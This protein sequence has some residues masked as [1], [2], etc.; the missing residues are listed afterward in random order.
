[1]TDS[2]QTCWHQ[3]VSVLLFCKESSATGKNVPSQEKCRGIAADA[4]W[5]AIDAV[6]DK[7]AFFI[8]EQRCFKAAFVGQSSDDA[9]GKAGDNAALAEGVSFCDGAKT[10][11]SIVTKYQITGY[12][13]S[14]G[15][16]SWA[17]A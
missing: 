6:A 13:N 8:L 10:C 16:G 12:F 15:H 2:P 7:A 9:V 17:C 11:P 14:E 4:I 5:A 3:F 1:M